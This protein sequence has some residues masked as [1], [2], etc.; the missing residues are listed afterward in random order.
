MEVVHNVQMYEGYEEQGQTWFLTADRLWEVKKILKEY[1]KLEAG[2]MQELKSLSGDKSS[3]AG[4]FV[5]EM[6]VRKGSVDYGS[7]PYLKGVDLEPYR[8]V[9]VSIWKLSK[10]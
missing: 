10:E 1:E 8:K 6:S 4:G 3:M 9:S 5:F 7:I 2:L